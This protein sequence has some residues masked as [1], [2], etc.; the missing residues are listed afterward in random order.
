[1]STLDHLNQH[2]HRIFTLSRLAR[3]PCVTG[4]MTKCW[5][6]LN[7]EREAIE[8]SSQC[9]K[10]LRGRSLHIT[11]QSIKR[12]SVKQL[13]VVLRGH[14]LL[15]LRRKRRRVR[16]RCQGVAPSV[17]GICARNF[18]NG[19]LLIFFFL[20]RIHRH[21]LAFLRQRLRAI[22]L[23]SEHIQEISI[24]FVVSAKRSQEIQA[25][26]QFIRVISHGFEH[27]NKG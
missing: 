20:Q 9:D 2:I 23:A 27:W 21:Q 14:C 5:L 12:Q 25:R 4:A 15:P 3:D 10:A 26:N 17:S 6:A 1:M 11:A 18:Q 22:R 24:K 16:Q 7:D 19:C 13:R 8:A